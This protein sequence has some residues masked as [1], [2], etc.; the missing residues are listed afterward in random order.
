[1]DKKEILA[2][3]ETY[4]KVLVACFNLTRNRV[5]RWPVLDQ[6]EVNKLYKKRNKSA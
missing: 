3:I 4:I 5:K 2:F 1:M 6:L